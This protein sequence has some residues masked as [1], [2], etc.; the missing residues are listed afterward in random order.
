MKNDA[1]ILQLDVDSSL[2]QSRWRSLRRVELLSAA[3]ECLYELSTTNIQKAGR[4]TQ[5]LVSGT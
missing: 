3:L 4:P 2:Q 5:G 1:A